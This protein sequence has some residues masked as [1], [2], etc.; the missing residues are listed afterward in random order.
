M[1]VLLSVSQIIK[2]DRGTLHV[3][4]FRKTRLATEQCTLIPVYLC[5]VCVKYKILVNSLF[6]RY[7][8]KAILAK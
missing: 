8:I 7:L 5:H 1:W 4:G 6:S 2:S 3:V